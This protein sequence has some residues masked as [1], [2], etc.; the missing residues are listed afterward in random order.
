MEL[1]ALACCTHCVAVTVDRQKALSGGGT[2]E[3]SVQV[4][5]ALA[6]RPSR[7]RASG[8][9]EGRFLG[10]Y[11]NNENTPAERRVGVRLK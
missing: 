4:A 9:A 3:A 2:P 10:P 7:G 5:G 8:L 11:S 1:S 6:G